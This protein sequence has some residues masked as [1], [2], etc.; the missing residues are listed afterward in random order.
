MV[1]V[2]SAAAPSAVRSTAVWTTIATWFARLVTAGAQVLVLRLVGGGGG[3]ESLALFVAILG[4]SPWFA[5][6]DLGLGQTIQNRIATA[7]VQG[8]DHRPLMSATGRAALAMGLLLMPAWWFASQA[9]APLLLGRLMNDPA[10]IISLRLVG[11]AL[12]TTAVGGIAWKMLFGEERGWLASLWV[13]GAAIIGLLSVWGCSVWNLGTGAQLLA[14]TA[15]PALT[16]LI[17]LVIRIPVRPLRLSGMWREAAAFWGFAILGTMTLSLDVVVLNHLAAQ[18]DIAAYGVLQRLLAFALGL[19][20][21]GLSAITPG[22][23]AAYACNDPAAIRRKIM[24]LLLPGLLAAAIMG[25][26][27]LVAGNWLMGLIG[28]QPLTISITALALSGVYL[29][30]RV[31]TDTMAS[32]LQALGRMRTLLAMIPVQAAIGLS[33]LLILVP[34]CGVSGVF[35]ALIISFLATAAWLLPLALHRALRHRD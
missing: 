26:F 22:L 35:A 18:A 5:L 3:V 32:A 11:L 8:E 31:W 14:W 30:L 16:A 34:R 24:L 28:G 29:L 1:E 6:A 19:Y 12:V 23:T 17:A 13:A 20:A 27:L 2:L 15:P 4:L 10:A 21:A 9:L 33:A 7:R 25:M